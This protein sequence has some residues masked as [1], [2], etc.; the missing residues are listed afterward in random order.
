[1]ALANRLRREEKRRVIV[2]IRVHFLR[3][4]LTE[5]EGWLYSYPAAI[6]RLREPQIRSKNVGEANFCPRKTWSMSIWTLKFD[7]S[8]HVATSACSR[9]ERWLADGVHVYF[10][11][12][13]TQ[14][15][16]K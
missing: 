11:F 2:R 7:S 8:E 12:Y 10:R 9:P 6:D 14:V 1:M 4:S 13:I 3:H 15:N 5:T 16:S